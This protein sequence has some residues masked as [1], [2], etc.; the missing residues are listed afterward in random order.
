MTSSDLPPLSPAN[1]PHRLS[2][3]AIE[4]LRTELKLALDDPL[5]RLQKSADL[6]AAATRNAGLTF[7]LFGFYLIVIVGS[8]SHDQLVREDPITLPLLDVSLPLIGFYWVGP[9]LFVV[10]HLNFL[11]AHY[12]LAQKLRRLDAEIDHLKTSSERQNARALFHPFPIVQMLVGQDHPPAARR[13][14]RILV[15]F[16]VVIFPVLILLF[17][18]AQFLPYHSHLVTSWHRLL[19]IADLWLLGLLW[20]RVLKPDLPTLTLRL[21]WIHLINALTTL[22]STPFWRRRTYIQSF[23]RISRSAK[24]G[25]FAQ[26]AIPAFLVSW[27][28]LVIPGSYTALPLDAVLGPERSLPLFA[29]NIVPDSRDFVHSKPSP[30]LIE[31]LGSGENAFAKYGEGLDLRG[32]D[33]RYADLKGADLRKADLSPKGD[34]IADLRGA[35]LDGAKMQGANLSSAKL[36]GTLLTN[37]QLQAANLSLAEAQGTVL[38]GANLQSAELSAAQFQGANLRNANLRGVDASPDQRSA[39]TRFDGAMLVAAKLEGANLIGAW[40]QGADLRSAKLWRALIQEPNETDRGDP[41]GRWQGADLRSV[42]FEPIDH[43]AQL[44]KEA[45]SSILIE[46]LAKKAAVRLEQSLITDNRPSRPILP[47]ASDTATDRQALADLLHELACGS[48]GSHYVAKGLLN[49]LDSSDNGSSRFDAQLIERLRDDCP[50]SEWLP[51]DWVTL[52]DLLKRFSQTVK[53]PNL[54]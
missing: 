14:L 54:N 28:I 47:A 20:R 6:A 51:E 5:G 50:P 23:A 31:Q 30:E 27:M 15:W 42:G 39:S 8:T 4:R 17:T 38:E 22:L 52:N 33:L 9:V 49:R 45:M 10:L 19:L 53:E 25:I 24:T 41:K 11:I 7:L 40:F 36:Q 32:R 3:E 1:A 29:R 48:G 2:A 43:P 16:V 21:A 18:Q 26:V 35:R 13:L 44:V 37:A 12:I 46:E 34:T